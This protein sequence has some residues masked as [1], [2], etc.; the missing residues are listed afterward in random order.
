MGGVVTSPNAPIPAGSL[1]ML[2]AT[3]VRVYPRIWT[4][5]LWDGTYECR[6]FGA[7]TG[8]KL[9]RRDQLQVLGGGA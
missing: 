6:T 3:L 7:R 2:G 9:A 8:G 4:G 1:A 5:S